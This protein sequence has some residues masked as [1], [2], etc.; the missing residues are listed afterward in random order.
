MYFCF[1]KN[2]RDN[3]FICSFRDDLQENGTVRKEYGIVVFIYF[4]KRLMPL[5]HLY[6]GNDMSSDE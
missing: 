6:C 5:G 3:L 1:L 2:N 4:I